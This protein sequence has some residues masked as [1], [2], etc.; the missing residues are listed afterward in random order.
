[1]KIYGNL[2][3]R[4]YTTGFLNCVPSLNRIL[5]LCA[6]KFRRQGTVFLLSGRFRCVPSLWKNIIWVKM[7]SAP[8]CQEAYPAKH[9]SVCRGCQGDAPYFSPDDMQTEEVLPLLR[10]IPLEQAKGE[11][12]LHDMTQII[13]GLSKGPAFRKGQVIGDTDLCRLHQM[14]RAHIYADDKILSD[15]EW[16][17]E[18]EAAFSFAK[19][20][21]GE[22]V[23]CEENAHEGRVNLRTA[24][25]G[26]LIFDEN[27]LDGFNP[28]SCGDG[29]YSVGFSRISYFRKK[30]RITVRPESITQS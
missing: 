21:A 16:V 7:R 20:M 15:P 27:Q 28:V 19:V 6:G 13:P 14:G 5:R 10:T 11:K 23:T 12:I 9:G 18:D 26:M 17:H 25:E 4:K 29:L 22:G 2:L 1:M 30:C 24:W 8:L 3:I